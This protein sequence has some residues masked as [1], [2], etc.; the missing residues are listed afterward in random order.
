MGADQK[1][2]M[3]HPD[4]DVSSDIVVNDNGTL[5]WVF[6]RV[7]EGLGNHKY[8]T[9]S[10]PVLLD[11]VG[12]RYK[13]HVF[14]IMAGQGLKIR[15]SDETMHNIHSLP[16]NSRPFNLAM[17][18]QGMEITKKFKSA[19]TMVRIKCD[20]HPWMESWAGVGVNP[21][22]AVTNDEGNFTI[23]NLPAGTFTIEIW[24]EEF[25]TQTKSVTIGDGE[26]K[27]T[28]FTLKVQA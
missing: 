27:A 20:V 7:T 8:D 13:P 21:F 19:E 16:K 11:Q 28:T 14:G 15:N 22:Y 6:V 4:G 3:M 26:S 1:C 24:H 10:E 18:R 25:G 2:D 23:S 9:P 17:P 5:K 12:C